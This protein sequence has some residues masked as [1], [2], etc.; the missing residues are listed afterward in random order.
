MH[1]TMRESSEFQMI[2]IEY[3]CLLDLSEMVS[4]VVKISFTASD[5]AMCIAGPKRS[6]LIKDDKH[7]FRIVMVELC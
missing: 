3:M 6:I 1:K 2:G 7:S 5:L 4:Y